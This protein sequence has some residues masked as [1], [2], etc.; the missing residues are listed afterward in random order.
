MINFLKNQLKHRK[1]VSDNVTYPKFCLDASNNDDIFNNFRNNDIYKNILE[2]VEFEVALKYF[3]LIKS[4]YRLSE[5]EIFD[6]VKILNRVGKPE[7]IKIGKDIP[8]LST[9]E[10]RYLYTGLEIKEF[11]DSNNL[12]SNNIIELGCG[13]GGQSL[14]LNELLDIK[15]YTYV[16]LDE[17]NFLIKRFLKNFS[18][19]FN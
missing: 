2:H 9:T 5:V 10:L 17:V 7:L 18:F 6:K 11:I 12:N 13:Y 8:K 1:S 14:I 19:N 16:D 3:D 4:K 15:H